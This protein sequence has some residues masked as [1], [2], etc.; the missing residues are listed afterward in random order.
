MSTEGVLVVLAGTLIAFV[1]GAN[2]VSK[3]IATLVGTGVSD[4][5]RALR[6]GTLWTA[7]GGLASTL[8]AGAM[9]TTFGTGLLSSA[10]SPTFAASLAS[11]LGAALWV[12]LATR[13]GLPV[14]TTHAIVGSMVGVAAIAY[15]VE[16]VQWTALATKV[17]L[18]LLLAPV[19]ALAG[20]A[21][22][23]WVWGAS[24]R[25]GMGRGTVECACVMVEPASAPVHDGAMAPMVVA[26]SLGVQLGTIAEC[27]AH[28]TAAK[29]TLNH[30]HW[31]TSGATSF[32]RGMN[33]APKMV[34]LVLAA[35]AL[36]GGTPVSADL[37]FVL[38]TAGMVTGSVLGGRRVTHV[39]ALQVTK[40][41]HTEG[42]AA[43]LV[44]SLLVATGAV[45]GLPMSTT[46][47]STGG[48]V[49]AGVQR[50]GKAV[51]FGKVR[52]L[53]LAWV[54]TLPAAALLG[55]GVHA[56]ARLVHG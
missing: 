55:V 27:A 28:P 16:G 50:G 49:G 21:G 10:S 32:A 41:N 56:V 25:R 48:I 29:V 46:H 47:V 5:R 4:Y 20:T 2:D 42:F 3:G 33:D 37:S 30:L 54:V 53:L 1:N 13:T 12:L 24:A 31:L 44:T 35:A 26:P 34:A 14:S 45:G 40:M 52:E 19:A 6:W 23:L 43:N 18:P 36:S 51:N 9:V 15:G 8:F 38:I 39:L 11:L 22:L 17:V 7:V